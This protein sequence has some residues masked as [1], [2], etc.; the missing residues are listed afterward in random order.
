MESYTSS[1]FLLCLVYLLR[2]YHKISHSLTI[3]LTNRFLVAIH[4]FSN[5]SQMMSVVYR[6]WSN[7]IGCY[8]VQRILI[9]P[10]KSCHSQTWFG[11]SSRMKAYSKSRIELQ[12]PR[13]LKK[14]LEKSRQFL[15]SEQPCEL[16]S[17]VVVL[18]T[19]GVERICSENL[20]LRSTLKAIRF[21]FWM[22]VTLVP[23][24]IC[25]FCGWWLWNQF[26][27]IYIF[28]HTHVYSSSCLWAVVSYT[29]SLLCPEMDWKIWVRKQGY[30]LILTKKW[31]FN[32][33]FLT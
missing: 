28:T 1:V 2:F 15:S 8:M 23:L 31:W 20:W 14:I 18:N 19:V 10:G 22:K 5:R 21:E 27:I 6:K 24:E 7:L 3:Y 9:G 11:A 16:K 29:C 33:S 4:L 30:M 13:I 25:V 26:D 32:V 12:N 17:L